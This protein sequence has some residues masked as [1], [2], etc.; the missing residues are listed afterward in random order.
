MASFTSVL[1]SM[2]ESEAKVV[3]GSLVKKVSKRAT[4]LALNGDSSITETV[5]NFKKA[6][7]DKNM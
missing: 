2:D 7:A 3:L 5:S 4:M 6:V 1:N